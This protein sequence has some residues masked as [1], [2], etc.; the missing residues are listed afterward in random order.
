MVKFLKVCTLAAAACLA[1]CGSEAPGSGA[2]A[3]QQSR[4]Q[5]AATEIVL[6]GLRADYTVTSTDVSV[7][8]SD[9]VGAGGAQTYQGAQRLH[10]ADASLAFDTSGNAGKTYRLYRAAFNRVPDIGGLSFWIGS[11]DGGVNMLNTA[12]GFM[13]SDEFRLL[14]GSN[15]TNADLVERFYRNVLQRAPEQA[16]YDYWLGLLNS[17]AVTRAYVLAEFSESGENKAAVAASIAAGIAYVPYP[18]R[19]PTLAQV[20]R[21][22]KSTI[23]YESNGPQSMGLRFGASG[24]YLFGDAFPADSEG[25]PGVE[26]G[27]ATASSSDAS[28]FRLT[29]QIEI[30]TNGRWG[31][32]HFDACVRFKF[33]G[34]TLKV[35][36]APSSTCPL[37]GADEETIFSPVPTSTGLVGAWA[38]HP[39][40]I[41]S[42]TFIFLPNGRFIVLDPVGDTEPNPC[43]GAGVEYGSYTFNQATGKVTITEAKFNTNGCAGLLENAL[44]IGPPFTFSVNPDNKSAVFEDALLYRVR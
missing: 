27:K 29:P 38:L 44:I 43:G 1:G 20:D 2:V 11:V 15:P 42:R 18:A 23:W 37:V 12:S 32:S 13:N 34:A 33:V 19:V 3:T 10:F 36:N 14:Y 28:G 24:E 17:G 31:L 5:A 30:D 16:G 4:A 26:Y 39:S 21:L 25:K 7:T 22:L 35:V 41:K 9:N 40:A 8:A 6:P